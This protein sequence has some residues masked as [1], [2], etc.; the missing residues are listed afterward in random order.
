MNIEVLASSSSGNAYIVD[1]GETVLLLD[2]GITLKEMQVKSN[3]KVNEVSACLLSHEH[4]DHSKGVKELLKRAVDVYAPPDTITALN[5]SGHRVHQA[6]V[7]KVF[8]VGSFKI[9]PVQMFHDCTCYG[10]LVQSQKTKEKLFFATDTYKITVNPK[11]IDYLILEVNYQMEIINRYVNDGIVEPGIRG[12]LLQSHF[13][14]SDALTWLNRI[15][16]TNLKRIYVAHLSSGNSNA[17]DIKKA[18]IEATGIPVT[19]CQ[20]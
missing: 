12:R 3:F 18:V 5:L 19:I 10:Y 8:E 7:S 17:E 14:L 9:L 4:G 11:N 1:D 20:A 2:A 13:E 6:E 15:D 16:K